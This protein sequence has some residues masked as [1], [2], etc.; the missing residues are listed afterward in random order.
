[1]SSGESL[2]P[3]QLFGA[4]P[5]AG[6]EGNPADFSRTLNSVRIGV[7]WKGPFS[8]AIQLIEAATKLPVTAGGE[9]EGHMAIAAGKAIEA[10]MGQVFELQAEARRCFSPEAIAHAERWLAENSPAGN[11]R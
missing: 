1:M 7:S 6:H 9:L 10:V 3:L 4:A 5:F 2:N 8:D 11:G